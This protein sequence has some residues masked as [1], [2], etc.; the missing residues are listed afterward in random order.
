M[1]T[2]RK[3]AG[4]GLLSM[5]SSKQSL[6]N[7][8]ARVAL[9]VLKKNQEMKSNDQGF[10]TGVSSTGTILKLT[11][12]AQD[13]TDTGR[14]GDSIRVVRTTMRATFSFADTFNIGRLIVARWNQDDTSSAP[15][16]ITDVLQSASPFSEY[17]RDN[18]RAKKFTVWYDGFFA[19]GATGPNIEKA[20]FDR[21][22]PTNI[23]YQATATTGTG[24]FY[25]FMVSDSAAVAHP[26]FSFIWR[27]YYTDS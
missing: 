22:M 23:A 10:G 15:T 2:K 26:V 1:E 16:G 3:N 25:A 6:D 7:E 17:H 5:P 8:I 13:N 27:T 12:I 11:S 9:K 19:V 24:N 4:K 20:V 21:S 14:D 18:L